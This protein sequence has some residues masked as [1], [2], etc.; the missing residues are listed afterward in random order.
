MHRS[1]FGLAVFASMLTLPLAAHA[2]TIDDFVL[3]GG[4]HTISYSYPATNIF[5]N[6]EYL[7]TA[8]FGAIDGVP[9]YTLGQGYNSNHSPF[10]TFQLYVP[11]SIFGYQMLQFQGPQLVNTVLVPADPFNQFYPFNLETTFIPGT[12]PLIGVGILFGQPGEGP[13]LPYTLTITPETETAAAP[14]PP[15]LDLLATRRLR[16]PRIRRH[17]TWPHRVDSIKVCLKN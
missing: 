5:L 14:E 11:E 7:Y 13:P 17:Q 12:Y 8:T 6:V 15:S 4:G 1:L 16:S 2:D 3:T 9:G 10:I